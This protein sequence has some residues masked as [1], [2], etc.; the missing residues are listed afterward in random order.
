M[1]F[2]RGKLRPLLVEQLRRGTSPEKLAQTLA[3]GISVSTC[4]IFGSTTFL[5][6]AVGAALGLNHALLQI[7]N[8]AAM[9]LQIL[10]I[11]P[12][13][14]L[15]RAVF[16]P[17]SAALPDLATLAQMS[18]VSALGAG[19]VALLRGTA[20]WAVTAPACAWLLYQALL[21]VVRKLKK[22]K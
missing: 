16:A 20:A 3:V 5:A 17:T 10:L 4:P 7:V 21:P 9:P 8:Y 2:W 12:Y 13:C 19:G 6:G 18:P 11:L 1:G 22:K 14:R 15:G